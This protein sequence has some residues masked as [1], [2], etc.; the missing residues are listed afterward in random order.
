MLRTL[1]TAISLSLLLALGLTPVA[2]D[3]VLEPDDVEFFLTNTGTACGGDAVFQLLTTPRTG[4]P[5][6]GWI[7]G[8]PFG[9]IYHQTGSSAGIKSY[10]AVEGI[11]LILDATRGVDG[12]VMIRH[13]PAAGV[14]Q[15]VIDVT[16]IGRT[17]NSSRTLASTTVETLLTAA[18]TQTPVPFELTLDADRDHEAL[19]SSL[20]ME[21]NVRGVHV[22]SGYTSSQGTSHF[23]LPVLVEVDEE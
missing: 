20:T 6:C 15:V 14:G 7:N 16:L 12:Q 1:L 17:G 4:G 22:S 11:P 2:A 18:T 19:F 3:T 13:S 8:L 10:V 9:E 23:T 21:T 5:N